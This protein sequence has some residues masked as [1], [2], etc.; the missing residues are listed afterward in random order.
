MKRTGS[1]LLISLVKVAI[2]VSLLVVICTKIDFSVLARHLDGGGAAD[3]FLGALLLAA[4][5]PLVATRWW[6]LLRNL[7]VEDLSL[8][9]AIGGTYASVFVGQATPGPVGADAVRA[10]LCYGRKV[11]LRV[12]VLSLVTDRLLATLGLIAV[13]GVVWFWQ[14]ATDRSVAGRIAIPG[15]IVLAATVVLLWVMPALTSPLAK[16]WQRFHAVHELFRMFR[17]AAFSRAGAFGFGLSCLVVALTVNAVMVFAHGFG[18]GLAP[19]VAYLVVPVVILF[20]SLPISIGG[21]GVRE[22]SLSYGLMLFGVAPNDAAS[23]GLALGIGLLIASL[24]GA[25]V[26]LML[27]LQLRA[28]LDR[29]VPALRNN[30]TTN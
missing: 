6:L 19:A 2:A 11:P 15:V 23:L 7:N 5:I 22:A 24:P 18:V 20:S 13:S 1:V 9:Y 17:V 21:W 27:G 14:F 29:A 26:M 4:N 8:G 25:V 12:I 28:V 10:W 30:P 3:L 16:R